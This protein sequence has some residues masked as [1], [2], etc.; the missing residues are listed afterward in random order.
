ME[1]RRNATDEA[2]FSLDGRKPIDD[3]I[4]DCVNRL[5]AVGAGT[6][7][8][9]E[10]A[11]NRLRHCGVNAPKI[12]YAPAKRAPLTRTERNQKKTARRA[13]RKAKGRA[14]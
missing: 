11:I 13:R 10:H 3:A 6:R 1:N 12:V 5:V 2:M 14:R 8:Q 9:I 4:E 7:S